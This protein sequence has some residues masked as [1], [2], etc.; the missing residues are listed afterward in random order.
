MAIEGAVHKFGDDIDTDVIIPAP[1]LVTGDAVEL[2]A[3]A[4]EGADP[5]FSRK[6]KPGDII[7]AGRN[8]GCGSS[9]EHAPI[10]LRGAGVACVIA[11]SF[12]RIFY[13]NAFNTGLLILESPQAAEEIDAGHRVRVEPEEGVIHDLTSGR[14][15]HAQPVPPFMQKLLESGGLMKFLLKGKAN[16]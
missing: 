13:R 8:F 12:A 4:M 6:V 3:H 1:Y 2:G 14:V 16:A 7:I 5:M 11:K 10:A 9:R 15:Y